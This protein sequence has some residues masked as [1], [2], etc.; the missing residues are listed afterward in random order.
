MPDGTHD[1]AV[2]VLVD[3]LPARLRAGSRASD[4]FAGRVDARMKTQVMP[5]DVVGPMSVKLPARWLL[6][7]ELLPDGARIAIVDADTGR[8]A[9]ADDLAVRAG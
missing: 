6:L 3:V 1:A 8:T 5:R 7:P 4:V 2:H 9:Y